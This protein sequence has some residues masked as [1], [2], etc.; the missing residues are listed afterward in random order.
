MPTH[1]GAK[2]RPTLADIEA[3]LASEP[4]AT[5]ESCS[6]LQQ[7]LE[8]D[9]D[10]LQNLQDFPANRRAAVRAAML[11]QIKATLAQMRQQG[12]PIS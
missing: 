1:E 9:Y 3:L 2:K 12:C 11:K 4:H 8:A 10:I 7:D 5:P 6:E